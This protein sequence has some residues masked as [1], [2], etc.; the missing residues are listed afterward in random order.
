MACAYAYAY[1]V[2][3]ACVWH[4]VR[5]LSFFQECRWVREALFGKSDERH[6]PGYTPGVCASQAAPLKGALPAGLA[7]VRGPFGDRCT[8]YKARLPED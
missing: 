4:M 8:T 3:C 6:D 5:T 7:K 2:W 1:G